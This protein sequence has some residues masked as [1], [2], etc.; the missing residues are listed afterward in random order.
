MQQTRTSKTSGLILLVAGG[1]QLVLLIT[2]MVTS[3]F[4]PAEDGMRPDWSYALIALLLLSIIALGTSQIRRP[5]VP[6]PL[7]QQVGIPVGLILGILSALLL[8][9]PGLGV[10]LTSAAFG[11]PWLIGMLITDPAGVFSI[12]LPF[13]LTSVVLYMVFA[14]S[15][16]LCASQVVRRRGL[17]RQGLWSS[18]QAVLATF[19][20]TALAFSL[21][22]IIAYFVFHRGSSLAAPSSFS[23][24][25]PLANY[26]A[27]YKGMV[28]L[29]ALWLLVPVVFGL[30]L[31]LPSAFFSRGPTFRSGFS[32][33]ERANDDA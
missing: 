1:L 9:I 21:I 16:C 8:Y 29:L 22:D 18:I 3:F 28:Q 14:A 12:S 30:L 4:F 6:P 20:S 33:A 11:L 27:S 2:S 7:S 25:S 19:L 26:V 5:Q 15:Y 10:P 23:D 17:V 31:A 24:F 32:A 13:A